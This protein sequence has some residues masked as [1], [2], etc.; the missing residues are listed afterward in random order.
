MR[1]PTL[2]PDPQEIGTV[3]D[4]VP[5]LAP[6]PTPVQIQ[7]APQ[8]GKLPGKGSSPGQGSSDSGKNSDL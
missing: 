2:A 6:G 3:K 5:G 8:P 7:S 4:S 1:S